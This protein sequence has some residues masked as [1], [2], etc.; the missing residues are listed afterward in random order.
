MPDCSSNRIDLNLIQHDRRTS[1]DHQF[2]LEQFRCQ[3]VAG[4][5]E[6]HFEQSENSV[7]VGHYRHGEFPAEFLFKLGNLRHQGC[8]LLSRLGHRME[9]S[10]GHLAL[11]V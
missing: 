5:D 7:L 2:L 6:R 1:R 3:Q 8:S 4:V 9:K 11:A 10:A